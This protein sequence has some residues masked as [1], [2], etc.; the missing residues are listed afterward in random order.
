MADPIRNALLTARSVKPTEAQKSAGKLPQNVIKDPVGETNVGSREASSLGRAP[1]GR[2]Q[3]PADQ[4][5]GLPGRGIVSGGAGIRQASPSGYVPSPGLEGLPTKV[6]IPMTGHVIEAGPDH[7]IRAIAHDYMRQAGLPYNPPT[8]YV[9][10]DPERTQRIAKAYHE[11]AHAPHNPLVKVAYQQMAREVAAQYHAAKK[12]GAKFEFW[13]P[14]KDEDP[15]KVS[16]RLVTED[17][18][19]NHHMYVFPTEWGFGTD[20]NHKEKLAENPLLADSGERWNGK[21]VLVNDLFRAIHDYYG[22]AKEGV[23]FRADGEENA[24]R[25]HAAM[26]S[27]LA[28]L[29]MTTETRGQNSWLNYGPHGE[30][31]RTARTEDTH[32]ADQKTGLLPPWVM[33]EGAEDFLTPE[34]IK[35]TQKAHREGRDKGGSVHAPAIIGKADIAHKVLHE[36]TAQ[37][38][39][40][41][42]KRTQ[43]TGEN[44]FETTP[45][46][47][48]RTSLIVPQK[49]FS[50]KYPQPLSGKP[51]PS[52]ER[53]KPIIDNAHAIAEKYASKMEPFKGK[54]VH[55]F[56]HTGPVYE[57]IAPGLGGIDKAHQSMKTFA[58]TY[59]GTSPRTA[60]EQNLGNSSL[61]AYKHAH[62]IPFDKTVI[63]TGTA[64]DK[65]YPMMDMHKDL[66]KALVEDRNMFN[67]NPKP[68]SF[69]QN[70]LGNHEGVTVDTHN[71]R[72]VLKSFD[73]LFP[74]ALPK[75]W[76]NTKED[77][78]DY[79]TTGLTSKLLMG[80]IKDMLESQALKGEKRQSEYGPMANITERAAKMIDVPRAPAQSLGWFGLGEHT[81]LKS[82]PSTLVDLLNQRINV[83]AQHLGVKPEV[84]RDLW[85]KHEVPLM[86]RGGKA[87][88]NA[89]LTLK[90]M[91]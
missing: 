1:E 80:G 13:N 23:G 24:W 71:I 27:P 36:K 79:K 6:K 31:N 54:N 72:G 62:G 75:E 35:K 86:N 14:E 65:G 69:M 43:P 18:R 25:S 7:R 46:A 45:A 2:A 50:T 20:P 34:E 53:M 88:R 63:D 11:M 8:K 26:F 9:K 57:G 52:N 55:Y 30:K 16:P 60:T 10:A 41:K 19:H 64:N 82:A 22:H 76:F 84:V 21:R 77:Y 81:N 48:E 83:T 32:F 89:M 85:A 87:I 70:V 58:A 47:Y 3:S 42:K 29:A 67:S 15:Y 74:G 44:V 40:D 66:T 56:Y 39:L 4:A 38:E 5:G 28:R 33:H 37:M 61:L 78:H 17:L 73:E 49:D 68:S 90:G 12:A 51:L 59:A 91:K